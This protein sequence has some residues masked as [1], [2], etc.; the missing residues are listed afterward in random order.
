VQFV[1]FAVDTLAFIGVIV[2]FILVLIKMFQRGQ[3]G[4]GILCI[5]LFFCCTLGVLIQLILGF[6]KQD[7]LGVRKIMPIYAVCYL[8]LVAANLG[9]NLSGNMPQFGR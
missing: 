4:L 7:E 6:M 9:L 8:I 5:V 1:L 2:C 3:T